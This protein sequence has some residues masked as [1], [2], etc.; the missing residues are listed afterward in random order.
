V[1]RIDA[2]KK[3]VFGSGCSSWYLDAEGVPSS[4]P[5][6]YDAFAEAMEAPQLENYELR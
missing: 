2:A 3:T 6:S 1:R 4:W 5:W